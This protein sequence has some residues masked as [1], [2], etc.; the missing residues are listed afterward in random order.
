MHGMGRG[1]L[2]IAIG[3]ARTIAVLLLPKAYSMS[4]ASIDTLIKRQKK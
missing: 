3:A 2:L 4:N 1:D